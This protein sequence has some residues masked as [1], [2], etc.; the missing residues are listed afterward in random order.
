[1]S[2]PRCPAPL[3]V[4]LDFDYAIS[5]RR[6]AAACQ[7]SSPAL[8]KE[9][10][11]LELFGHSPAPTGLLAAHGGRSL[12][13]QMERGQLSSRQFYELVCEL[14]GLRVDFS[15]FAELYA[16]IFKPIPP[17]IR[18]QQHLVAAGVPTYLLSNVSAL[19][20]DDAR[21]R[22]PFLQSF[23]GLCLS[24]EV[25]SSRAAAARRW[26][27]CTPPAEAAMHRAGTERGAL[28]SH[29]HPC[30]S[31]A[32]SRTPRSTQQPR[33]WQAARELTWPSSTTGPTTWRQ[34]RRGA[35]RRSTTPT[36][37]PRWRSLRRWGCPRLTLTDPVAPSDSSASMMQVNTDQTALLVH[38][39]LNTDTSS[40]QSCMPVGLAVGE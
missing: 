37:A 31:A 2:S 23:T 22:H 25:R 14:A 6:L 17:M 12:V 3:Q 39:G 18:Q 11:L 19:H 5:S 15:T 38:L 32:S 4:L 7:A 28:L 16:D 8:A 13:E 34:R 9:A 20:I 1:M 10:A 36:R 35:G 21:R 26:V 30:R 40:E 29:L 24:Y 33:R 27:K